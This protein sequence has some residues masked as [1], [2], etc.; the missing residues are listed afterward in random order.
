MDNIYVFLLF[1]LIMFCLKGIYFRIA[2]RYNIIDKP[3]ER[4]SHSLVTVR[5]GGI[6]FPIA[7]IIYCLFFELEHPFFIGGLLLLS[8]VSFIDD[9]QELNGQIRMVFQFLCVSLIFVETGLFVSLPIYVIPLLIVFAVATI[10][11]WNFMDGINGITGGYSLLTIMTLI[12]V[13]DKVVHFT[14]TSF[15]VAISLSLLVFIFYNFRTHARCF[16]GDVG[17]ISISFIIVFLMIQLVQTTGNSVFILFLLLYG[18]DAVSTVVFRVLRRENILMAHRSHFYQYLANEKG[19]PHNTVSL[20]Y[21]FIQ[22]FVNVCVVLLSPDGVGMLIIC[23]ILG[24]GIFLFVRFKIEGK[25]YLLKSEALR[26][27]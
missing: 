4:S 17:S 21:I 13:N 10:N 16:A 1:F 26:S 3:N 18:L 5:G 23:L 12:Y 14:S 6:I 20:I 7:A 22:L 19:L 24:M 15:M 27:N 11:A 2:D 8:T 9:V 25:E